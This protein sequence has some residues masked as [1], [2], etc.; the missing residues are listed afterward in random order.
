MEEACSTYGRDEKRIQHFI[1]EIWKEETT[2]KTY[3]ENGKILLEL[4]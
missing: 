4:V 1:Q 2:R 3:A